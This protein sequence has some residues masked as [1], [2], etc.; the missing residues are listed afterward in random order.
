M[1]KLWILVVWKTSTKKLLCYVLE[2]WFTFVWIFT[3][4][5]FS[6]SNCVSVAQLFCQWLPYDNFGKIRTYQVPNQPWIVKNDP[7]I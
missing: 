4:N 3:R 5:L 6:I 2:L 1:E 7:I